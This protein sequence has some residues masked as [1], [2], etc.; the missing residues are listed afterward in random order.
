MAIKPADPQAVI[1][2][3]ASG[4]LTR[5]KLLPAFYHLFVEGLLPEGFAIIGYARTAMADEQ[6]REYTRQAIVKF[7]RCDPA[8]E[9]R[10]DFARRLTYMTREFDGEGAR[11]DLR[12]HLERR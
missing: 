4:D 3:G 2:F 7:A 11:A 6:F 9:E 12:D 8:G 5:R 1:I 10:E